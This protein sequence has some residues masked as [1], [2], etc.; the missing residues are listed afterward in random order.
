M[1]FQIPDSLRLCGM[2]LAVQSP[3]DPPSDHPLISDAEN[4]KPGEPWRPM[5][6]W[7]SANNRGYTA[8]WEIDEPGILFLTSISGRFEMK[9]GPLLADWV[10]TEFHIPIG[11]I[12]E[13]LTKKARYRVVRKYQLQFSLLKG[14]ITKWRLVKTG[15]KN[16][17]A[18]ID[19]FDGNQISVSL[20][21]LGLGVELQPDRQESKPISEQDVMDMLDA[22]ASLLRF[23][24]ANWG[25]VV[26][27]AD[28]PLDAWSSLS[29]S[30]ADPFPD[31]DVHAAV[32][33]FRGHGPELNPYA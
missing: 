8:K 24:R 14:M 17:P 2:T 25:S 18:W 4:L 23:A 7:S 1:S 19:G 9:N 20:D 15:D 30:W 3:C 5:P 28:I 31:L 32:R 33:T 22:S 13:T 12:D 21:S 26:G 27:K 16:E 11:E 6:I 29:K 10:S